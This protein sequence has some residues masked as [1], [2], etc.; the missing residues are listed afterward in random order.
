MEPAPPPLVISRSAE[1]ERRIQRDGLIVALTQA[2][3]A[4]LC[5]GL[6]LAWYL[7]PQAVG[8]LPREFVV[9]PVFAAA[10]SLGALSVQVRWRQLNGRLRNLR[11]TLA[12][13]GVSYCSAA[14]TYTAP[15]SAVRQVRIHDRGSATPYVVVD[16][17]GWGGPVCRGMNKVGRLAVSLGDSGVGAPELRRAVHLFSQGRVIAVRS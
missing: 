4:L 11:L 2:A 9:V 14:G 16:V 8:M 3:A 6:A 1:Q 12:R 17:I 13:E 7:S 15:W 10:C 5:L